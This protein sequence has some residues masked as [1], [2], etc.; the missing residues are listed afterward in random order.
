V[1]K[2]SVSKTNHRLSWTVEVHCRQ[3]FVVVSFRKWLKLGVVTLLWTSTI[4][5]EGMD[6]QIVTP[7]FE[8]TSVF[9]FLR[10]SLCLKIN[11]W[12]LMINCG[13]NTNLIWDKGRIDFI[14]CTQSSL[15]ESIFSWQF[16]IDLDWNFWT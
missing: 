4:W 1:L 7:T 11:P 2:T 12:F 3:E 15:W 16:P 14:R 5:R 13:S 10:Y 9:S 8:T 6:I